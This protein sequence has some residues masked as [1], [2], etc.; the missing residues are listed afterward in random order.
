MTD[1]PLSPDETERY[2]RHLVLPEIGGAGQQKLK[3]ARVL[4]VGAGGLGAPAIQYL[5]AAGIGHLTVV[6]HDA[7]SLSNLQRQVLY[8]T[9]DVGVPK[10]ERAFDAVMRTNPYV[11]LDPICRRLDAHNIAEV[12]EGQ[13]LALDATDNFPVRYALADACAAAQIPLIT[14][15]VN[16]FDGTITTLKPWLDGAPSYRD[17]FP[18]EPPAGTLPT[19]AEAGILG[20]VTGLLGTL[21]ALEAVKEICGFGEGLTGRLLMVDALSLRFTTIQTGIQTGGAR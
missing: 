14:A 9:A 2:A 3:R 8:G 5:A 20:A 13:T 10:V 19:C 16:R 12:V 15:A 11:E 4:V 1:T 7:V 21:Q 18:S 6:D 17:L